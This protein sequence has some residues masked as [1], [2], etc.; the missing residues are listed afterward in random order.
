MSGTQGRKPT[1][2]LDEVK[3]FVAQGSFQVGKRATDFI[4]NRYAGDPN[5]IVKE[6]F[7]CMKCSGFRKTMPLE[8]RPDKMAD[9]Y[10]VEYDD[11]EW[12]VKFF[13]DENARLRIRV[14]S[15]NWDDCLH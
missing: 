10:A 13:V 8:K 14:W 9:V 6:V 1:Y 7:A 5:D 2:N 11:I 3:G 15:C 12:Y 4:I